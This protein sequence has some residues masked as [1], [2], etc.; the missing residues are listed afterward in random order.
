MISILDTEN[1]DIDLTSQV[2]VLTH[3][4]S[5]T[6]VMECQARIQFGDG[7]KNLDGTGG[8]FELTL[9]VG[10]VPVEPDPQT[11]TFSTA[12]RNSVITSQFPVPANAEVILKAKSPNAA[13]TDV[14]VVAYL[15]DASRTDV[16]AISGDKVS[17]DNLESQYDTTGLTGDTFPATQKQIDNVPANVADGVWDEALAGHATAGTA[18]SVL[19][20]IR[21]LRQN[22]LE[23]DLD[24]SKAYIWNDAGDAR[25]YEA[26]LTDSNGAAVAAATQ[27]PI[28][29]TEWTAV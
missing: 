19:D 9:T 13:D 8:D 10:G 16:M 20:I 2:I 11:I 21:L 14:D 29:C 3:T 17:A 23:I 28:N 26:T 24:D 22:R 7:T 15:Y 5:V 12:T 18:G 25:A 1:A 6:D 27:G 4:P